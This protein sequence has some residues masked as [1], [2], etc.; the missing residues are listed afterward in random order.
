M[1]FLFVLFHHCASGD[2]FSTVSIST[3]LLDRLLDV[4]IL[5]LLL[6]THAF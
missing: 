4:L 3:A 1:T 2:L 5:A 6:L